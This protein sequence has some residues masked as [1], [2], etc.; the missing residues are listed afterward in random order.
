MNV[1][2]CKSTCSSCHYN[3]LDILWN[4]STNVFSKRITNGKD[5]WRESMNLHQDTSYFHHDVLNHVHACLQFPKV[6][7]TFEHSVILACAPE[8]TAADLIAERLLAHIDKGKMFRMYASS[9]PWN[10][11]SQ[12][13][14]VQN[15]RKL[16]CHSIHMHNEQP[17]PK[18]KVL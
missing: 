10:F 8:N 13:L 14:K 12:K 3:Q 1:N 4:S 6:Y 16:V 5:S 9:R 2:S 17:K 18:L 15:P 7:S 11:V